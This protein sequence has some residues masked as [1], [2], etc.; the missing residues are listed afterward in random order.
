[1]KLLAELISESYRKDLEASIDRKI[2][3]INDM[4]DENEKQIKQ[5]KRTIKA[6]RGKPKSRPE[7]RANTQ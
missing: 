6:L 7:I 2:K 5:N 3:T 4:A 1:M